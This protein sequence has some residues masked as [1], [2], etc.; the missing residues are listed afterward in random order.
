MAVKMR[1][2]NTGKRK[3]PGAISL[4]I[5]LL[6]SAL[7]PLQA[8]DFPIYGDRYDIDLL[9]QM[10]QKGR[11]VVGVTGTYSAGVGLQWG[12]ITNLLNLTYYGWGLV[13]LTQSVNW[14][15]ASFTLPRVYKI[16]QMAIQN[17]SGW[18]PSGYFEIRSSVDGTT[19]VTNVE[20][21]A[22]TASPAASNLYDHAEFF[23]PTDAKYVDLT[24][25]GPSATGPGQIILC[26][27]QVYAATNTPEPPQRDGG[28]SIHGVSTLDSWRGWDYDGNGNAMKYIKDF[29]P[30][31]MINP[32]N[33]RS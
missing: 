27:F 26:S 3:E 28:F 22:F 9:H 5:L 16:N 30:N 17:G 8:A 32:T 11:Y 6:L 1:D 33:D 31:N 18:S 13:N 14:A 25:S 4:A 10:D 2:V 7:L 20:R 24:V 21:K 15:R 29:R 12:K 23:A 19:W